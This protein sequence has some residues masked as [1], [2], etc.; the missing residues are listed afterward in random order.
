M[1]TI[2]IFR[3]NL[4]FQQYLITASTRKWIEKNLKPSYNTLPDSYTELYLPN[5]LY[6]RNKNIYLITFTGKAE[7]EGIKAEINTFKEDKERIKFK[8]EKLELE[9]EDPVP[10][11]I[12]GMLR[13]RH[14]VGIV[15]KIFYVVFLKV[16][17]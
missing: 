1:V 15:R 4:I 17:C 16:L 2:H 3:L 7:V 12:R 10:K 8:M 5:T 11:N 6:Y 13:I 14:K 9:Q